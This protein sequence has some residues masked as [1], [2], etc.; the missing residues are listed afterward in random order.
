V[1]GIALAQ[2]THLREA[3]RAPGNACPPPPW[4]PAVD[5]IIEDRP[6]R[7]EIETIGMTFL[8]P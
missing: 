3:G 7:H 6:L 2:L 4:M 1:L 8:M 5:A